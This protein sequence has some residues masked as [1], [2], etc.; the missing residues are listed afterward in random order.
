M[1]RKWG[2]R[3]CGALAAVA[4]LLCVAGA[5]ATAPSPTMQPAGV[6]QS[7]AMAAPQG[8]RRDGDHRP[9]PYADGGA[10]HD[11][12]DSHAGHDHGGG[13]DEGD[14]SSTR[15]LRIVSIF[16]TAVVTGACLGVFFTKRSQTM[17]PEGLLVLRSTSA[18]A[19]DNEPSAAETTSDAAG[20]A[21]GDGATARA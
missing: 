8:S 14:S 4:I 1:A 16:V 5:A 13:D 11:D 10:H 6:H 9:A 18:G 21:A 20:T 2:P 3:P 12:E 17:S 7:A 19:S 15:T